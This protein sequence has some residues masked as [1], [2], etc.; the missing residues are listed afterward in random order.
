MNLQT[1]KS[2]SGKI[3]YVLLPYPVYRNLKAPI[4]KEL[5]RVSDLNDNEFVPFDVADYIENPVALARIKA[6]LRQTELANRL[7][8]SQAYISKV[9]RQQSVSPKL[10]DR[11]HRALSKKK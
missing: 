7:R 9:E 10:L 5:S 11:V 3:E 6:H 2:T 8:V 1:I 4:E